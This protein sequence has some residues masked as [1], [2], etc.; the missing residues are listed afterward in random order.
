MKI[1]ASYG[2][3]S[4]RKQ[5]L[6]FGEE[7]AEFNSFNFWKPMLADIDEELSLF[8]QEK[9]EVSDKPSMSEPSTPLEEAAPAS[10]FSTFNYW[11][12]PILDIPLDLDIA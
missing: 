11:R 1:G 3:A 9:M 6:S 10:Q 4:S 2:Y 12:V 5:E 7:K 8:L